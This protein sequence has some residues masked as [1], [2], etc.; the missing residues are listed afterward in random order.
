MLYA[1]DFQLENAGTSAAPA[2][3]W[4]EN[5]E[6]D[7]PAQKRSE[8][9]TSGWFVY[10]MDLEDVRPM[11]LSERDDPPFDNATVPVHQDPTGIDIIPTRLDVMEQYILAQVNFSHP[12][13]NITMMNTST[14]GLP[15]QIGREKR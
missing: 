5:V 15:G 3:Y 11:S 4:L 12:L 2:R 10:D 8:N 14:S 1:F 13:L 6:H 9:N 7:V